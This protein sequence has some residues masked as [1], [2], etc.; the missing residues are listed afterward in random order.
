MSRLRS[1]SF[2]IQKKALL[3]LMRSAFLLSL[4]IKV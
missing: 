4:I 2:G 1:R 3:K